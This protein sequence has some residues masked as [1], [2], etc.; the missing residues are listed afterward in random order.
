[1]RVYKQICKSTVLVYFSIF[2]LKDVLS[3]LGLQVVELIKTSN[4]V[5]QSSLL[6]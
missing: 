2:E 6:E 3:L 1:M 4:L 5:H